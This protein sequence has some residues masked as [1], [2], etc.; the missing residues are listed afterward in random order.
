VCHAQMKQTFE[1]IRNNLSNDTAILIYANVD[2]PS[3]IRMLITKENI[4]GSERSGHIFVKDMMAQYG[5]DIA[6]TLAND[7]QK[8]KTFAA[9]ITY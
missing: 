3:M 4:S 2:Q 9:L 6:A 8:S 1:H 7:E 5:S